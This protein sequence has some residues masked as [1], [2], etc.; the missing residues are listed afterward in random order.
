MAIDESDAMGYE[1]EAD[2]SKSDQD[3]FV[4]TKFRTMK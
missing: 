4:I 3:R 2:V 1:P